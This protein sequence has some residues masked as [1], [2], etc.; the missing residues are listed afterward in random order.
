MALQNSDGNYLKIESVD[1][2]RKMAFVRIYKDLNTRQ[3]PTE[4]DAFVEK[5]FDIGSKLQE[6]GDSFVSTGNLF[7]DVKKV[8]YAALKNEPPF[9]GASG[10]TWIDT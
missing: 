6:E 4:F 5:S 2:G 1:L 3:S 8:G 7:D 9:N 10:E